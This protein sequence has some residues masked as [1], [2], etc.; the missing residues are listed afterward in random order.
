MTADAKKQKAANSRF[1]RLMDR[2]D[3]HV[4]VP[5]EPRLGVFLVGHAADLHGADGCCACCHGRGAK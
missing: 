3:F 1:Y 2:T 4:R 5:N